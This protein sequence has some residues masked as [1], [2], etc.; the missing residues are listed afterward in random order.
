MEEILPHARS[1]QFIY[2]QSLHSILKQN[3]IIEGEPLDGEEGGT[4]LANSMEGKDVGG[5]GESI[6]Y[7]ALFGFSPLLMVPRLALL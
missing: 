7:C 1:P 6:A 5:R 4:L 3:V 2:M